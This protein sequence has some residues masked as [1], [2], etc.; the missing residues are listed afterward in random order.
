MPSMA[1]LI[2]SPRE[3][4]PLPTDSMLPREVALR[5]VTSTTPLSGKTSSASR[6][7]VQFRIWTALSVN[8]AM[9]RK[10]VVMVRMRMIFEELFEGILGYLEERM[11]YDQLFNISEPKRIERSK[12]VRGP[13]LEVT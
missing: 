9:L 3:V 1:R 10:N 5:P 4:L 6:I 13:P 2:A 12:T 7:V 8:S 11:T